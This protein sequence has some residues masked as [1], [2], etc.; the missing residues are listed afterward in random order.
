MGAK[1][2]LLFLFWKSPTQ[3][4]ETTFFTGYFIGV[5][6]QIETEMIYAPFWEGNF[7]KKMWNNFLRA[8]LHWYKSKTEIVRCIK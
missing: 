3:R 2:R 4:V 1:G 7:V 8:A 5:T 6:E